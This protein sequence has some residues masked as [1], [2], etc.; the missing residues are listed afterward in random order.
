MF[1]FEVKI[2]NKNIKFEMEE[3]KKGLEMKSKIIEMV[4]ICLE[5]P[6]LKVFAAGHYLKDELTLKEQ[7][8]KDKLKLVL[9]KYEKKDLKE[10]KLPPKIENSPK[11]EKSLELSKVLDNLQIDSNDDPKLSNN[12]LQTS[13]EIIMQEEQ[14]S[15]E[16][17]NFRRIEREAKK[18]VERMV[19][20][21][22]KI[23]T[24]QGNSYDNETFAVLTDGE[25]KEFPLSESD[26]IGITCG[27]M[28]FNYGKKKL[29]NGKDY[30]GV[31]KIFEA[32]ER[33]F[34]GVSEEILEM[35]DNYGLLCLEIGWAYYKMQKLDE[36]QNAS[37]KLK[38]ANRFLEKSYGKEMER[39]MKVTGG[40]APQ[41]A[42]YARLH[43]L[44]GI[45]R[46][47]KGFFK[48]SISYLKQAEDEINQF[49]I[50]PSDPNYLELL[51]IGYD[52]SSA[53]RGLRA[54][55]RNLHEAIQFL[56]D[57]Q[58]KKALIE[59]LEREKEEKR[60]REMRY[61]ATANGGRVNLRILQY[62]V[63]E[64][65]FKE[66]L[67]VEALKQVDN[68]QEELSDLLTNPSRLQVLETSLQLKKEERRKKRIFSE[69]RKR[70]E[71][72]ISNCKKMLEL[73]FQELSS[74][75]ALQKTKGNLEEA[76][77]FLS[78]NGDSFL[79]PQ[80]QLLTLSQ[81]E[82]Q[83]DP[84]QIGE[85]IQN[86][87]SSLLT[88][89]SDKQENNGEEEQNVNQNELIDP[90]VLQRQEEER[91]KKEEEQLDFE[92]EDELKEAVYKEE[93][94]YLN[95]TLDDEHQIFILYKSLL[96]SRNEWY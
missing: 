45:I 51:N 71:E 4:D 76:I 83:Y 5:P 44:E 72:L 95:L 91:R 64:L 77:L 18:T 92:M 1:H 43:L 80:E 37:Q 20:I 62:Y 58:E 46:F 7:I 31:L 88:G 87:F 13:N 9:A 81:L 3:D 35:I 94:N 50:E 65:G 70:D 40:Y 10:K 38:S 2:D 68:N 29:K 60:R 79:H 12:E 90:L 32:A 33:E 56:A 96:E 75:A 16:V 6:K 28:L 57:E 55:N 42:L 49:R 8:N 82:E 14:V 47:H 69:K 19:E 73:G 34:L 53:R 25:G 61:G 21:A 24:R 22:H 39:L 93:N 78:E 26:R 85:G 59:K 41:K 54:A 15:E 23:A 74:I 84:P 86:P 30:E 52:E 48:D 27:Q 67:V 36:L 63:E 89:E 66:S 11:I 17:L